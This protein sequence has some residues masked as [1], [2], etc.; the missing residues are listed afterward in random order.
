MKVKVYHRR[1]RNRA[2]FSGLWH[3][4]LDPGTKFFHNGRV[5]EIIGS[6]A[7]V[8]KGEAITMVEVKG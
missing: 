6:W 5:Y 1:D 8:N 2:L 3:A 4:P 7:E